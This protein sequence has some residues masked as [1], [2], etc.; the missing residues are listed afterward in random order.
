MSG[1]RIP[2]RLQYVSEETAR[3][4]IELVADHAPD[5]LAVAVGEIAPHVAESSFEA[6]GTATLRTVALSVG[7]I[8][9]PDADLTTAQLWEAIATRVMRAEEVGRLAAIRAEVAYAAGRLERRA[10]IAHDAATMLRS[11]AEQP[12]DA[13]ERERLLREADSEDGL[14]RRSLVKAAD[15]RRWL[16]ATR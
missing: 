14:A 16:E 2:G 1:R 3:E 15:C 11:Y 6:G 7:A 10:G 5:V 9:D 13:H 8:L 4:L 12:P